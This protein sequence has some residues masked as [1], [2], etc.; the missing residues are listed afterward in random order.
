MGHD[1]RGVDRRRF[2]RGAAAT[3]VA[4]PSAG[5]L[6][7]ATPALAHGG[8]RGRG[9]HSIPRE[10]ISIQLYTL[11]E[12]PLEQQL[13]G[14]AEI[15]YKTVEH[16]GFGSLTAAEFRAALKQ[17]GIR[18]TSGHQG[19]PQ[20][21]DATAWR[22]QVADA[23]TVGQRY[24]VCPASP[25]VF[26]PSGNIPDITGFK[27]AAEWRAYAG[28]LN[29]AG[30]IARAAGLRFGYHNHFWEFAALTDDTPL[31]GYDVMLAETDPDLVHFEVDLYWTWYAHRDPV[32]LL[33]AFGDR[34]RQFHVKDMRYVD[35]VPSWADVGTGVIDFARIFAAAGDPNRH[36]YIVER[37][38]AGA[39]ALSTA[40]AG[41]SYLRRLRF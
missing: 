18:A 24:I 9:R 20:P 12:L 13:R 7:A 34:I 19:I 27:T 17:Y 23:V 10:Q 37:D 31:T 2:L 36:E 3:A 32:Q 41:Y 15:G 5:G 16:A 26:P 8:D 39:G 21:F 28:D 14:L 29:K 35:H 11:R 30:A 38:D 4:L 6:A 40:A 25:I 1:Q 33:A 22:K